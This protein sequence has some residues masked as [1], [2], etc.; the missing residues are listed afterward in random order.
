MTTPLQRYID[1]K[2]VPSAR[3]EALLQKRLQK[4]APSRQQVYRWRRTGN[5]RRVDMVRLLW[6]VREATNDPTV[7]IDELFDFDPDNAVNWS[8]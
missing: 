1:A 2:G 3:I 4:N 7:R 5:I 6:A 8:D